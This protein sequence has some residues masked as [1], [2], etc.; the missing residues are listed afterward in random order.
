VISD[1]FSSQFG[2]QENPRAREVKPI[3]GSHSESQRDNKSEIADIHPL[4]E[5]PSRPNKLKKD[6]QNWNNHPKREMK[7]K[8]PVLVVLPNEMD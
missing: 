8:S 2:V 6:S 5:T 1:S 3:Q 4:R 7:P